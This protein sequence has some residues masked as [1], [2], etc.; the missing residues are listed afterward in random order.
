MIRTLE[1]QFEAE[2]VL[3]IRTL[4]AAIDAVSYPTGTGRYLVAEM[5]RALEAGLLLAA[6]QLGATLLDLFVK[7][8]VVMSRIGR[9]RDLGSDDATTRAAASEPVAQAGG[10]D[11]KVEED[12]LRRAGLLRLLEELVAAELIDRAEADAARD[13]YLALRAP[14][15]RGFSGRIERLGL[16]ESS[17][18]D[19][20]RD[21]LAD[22][23]LERSVPFFELEREIEERG[24]D[25]LETIVNLIASRLET[26][27]DLEQACSA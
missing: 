19:A 1:E 27:S 17:E 3:R 18:V 9:H 26:W 2:T 13:V 24:L 4:I 23:G 20:V 21:L 11:A 5:K 16:G 10:D 12:A 25:H 22:L 8:L 7:D 15:Q 14:F 6:T